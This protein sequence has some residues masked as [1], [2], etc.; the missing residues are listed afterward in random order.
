M[1]VGL[2]MYRSQAPRSVVLCRR[3]RRWSRQL[4]PRPRTNST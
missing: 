2:Y 1:E 3:R 4:A